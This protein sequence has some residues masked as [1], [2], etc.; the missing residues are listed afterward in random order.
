MQNLLNKLENLVE[1]LEKSSYSNKGE[2]DFFKKFV[3]TEKGIRVESI[4]D[5]ENSTFF[6]AAIRSK[7]KEIPQI[8][9][10]RR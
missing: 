10:I 7:Y 8:K 9:L 4:L 1:E 3:K 6:V 5:Y 2:L